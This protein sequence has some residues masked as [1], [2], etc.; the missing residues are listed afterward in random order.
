MSTL[1]HIE[2]PPPL[3]V[4]KEF[5]AEMYTYSIRQFQH[6]MSTVCG[7]YCLFFIYMICKGWCTKNIL[8]LFAEK[9]NAFIKDV[10]INSTLVKIFKTDQDVMAMRFMRW[11]ISKAQNKNGLRK[12]KQIFSTKK[13]NK[14][15]NTTL[16]ERPL[17]PDPPLVAYKEDS[18]LWVLNFQLCTL[19]LLVVILGLLLIT[20]GKWKKDFNYKAIDIGFYVLHRNACK[21]RRVL[22]VQVVSTFS[23]AL[24]YICPQ[25]R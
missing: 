13:G 21:P 14:M 11:E 25:A 8:L 16:Y 22:P 18:S 23:P 6:P 19:V 20:R 24:M 2:S 17:I 1:I 4:F 15:E 7:Q 12:G 9:E 10:M 3:E 5:L